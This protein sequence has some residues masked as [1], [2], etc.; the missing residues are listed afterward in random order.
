MRLFLLLIILILS[1]PAFAVEDE[2]VILLH[3]LGRTASSMLRIEMELED[4]PPASETI[5]ENLG[6]TVNNLKVRRHRARQARAECV[7]PDPQDARGSREPSGPLPEGRN[8]PHARMPSLLPV[9][10]RLPLF[11]R[12]QANIRESPSTWRP[13]RS[14]WQ[15]L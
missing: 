9:D 4:D 5:A 10:R 7:A 6:I 11:R 3:G 14:G 13:A 1:T 8:A 2:C 12:H 15:N